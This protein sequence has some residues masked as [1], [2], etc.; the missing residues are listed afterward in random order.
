MTTFVSSRWGGRVS[1]KHLM[2]NSGLLQKLLPRDV[3]LADRGFDVGEVVAI[4]QASLHIPA[5]TKG[6]EQ[7]PPVEV[8]KSCKL[9]NVCI[10][11]ERV[12]GATRLR[13]SI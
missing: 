8:E 12:I 11:I 2:L 13:F 4:S 5:F 1:D 9:A 7:L 10:H 6:L 3:V